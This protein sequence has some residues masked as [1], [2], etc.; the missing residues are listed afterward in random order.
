MGLIVKVFCTYRVFLFFFLFYC[1]CC[2][3]WQAL[4]DL[5]RKYMTKKGPVQKVMGQMRLLSREDKARLLGGSIEGEGW[6][7]YLLLSC[8]IDL[9]A[10][11]SYSSADMVDAASLTLV[12]LVGG[13]KGEK[14]MG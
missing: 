8:Q 13:P 6:Q 3:C 1:G 2:C 4:E 12:W 11:Y 9:T 7:C 14:Q 10:V 5:R